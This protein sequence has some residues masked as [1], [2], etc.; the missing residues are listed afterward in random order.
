M[1][2]ARDLEN[3]LVKIYPAGKEALL[4]M[5]RG[6]KP[7]VLEKIMRDQSAGR[8]IALKIYERIAALS[9]ET[10][11]H[12]ALWFINGSESSYSFGD[13][14]IAKVMEKQGES[15]FRALF[16]M[17]LLIQQPELIPVFLNNDFTRD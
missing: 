1:I 14:D 3:Y 5:F 10:L 7:K 6:C 4:K 9:E 12:M 8:D 16:S 2:A 17:D 13:V 11:R 15:Y